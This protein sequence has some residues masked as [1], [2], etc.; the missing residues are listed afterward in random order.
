MAKG[1]T[2]RRQGEG[3]ASNGPGIVAESGRNKPQLGIDDAGGSA[4]EGTLDVREKKLAGLG[5]AASDNNNIGVKNPN[6]IG[7]SRP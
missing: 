2:Y 1:L 6:H 4:P 5:H 7:K 3:G